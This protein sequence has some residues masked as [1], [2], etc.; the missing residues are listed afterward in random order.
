[1]LWSAA[2]SLCDKE[3]YADAEQWLLLVTNLIENDQIDRINASI[4]FR[5]I[6]FCQI[7]LRRFTEAK[8][9]LER[10]LAQVA[11]NARTL[12][13][14]CI[15]E[16]ELGDAGEFTKHFTSLLQ[17]RSDENNS[18]QSIAMVMNALENQPHDTDIS[19]I[20]LNA[21]E[22]LLKLDS[23]RLKQLE[24]P[25]ATLIRCITRSLR[26][27]MPARRPWSLDLSKY[28]SEAINLSGEMDQAEIDWLA[29]MSWNLSLDMIQ[30][31]E[32]RLAAS[33][34]EL[35][36]QVFMFIIKLHM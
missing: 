36:S 13:L 34:I 24:I 11:Q 14:L 25:H 26:D 27:L 17:D 29:R 22:S 5:K 10:S 31:Q 20:M 9:Y 28:L 15:C 4:V 2:Q 33:Y 12:A 16:S 32:M 23:D 7:Q 6:A 19:E 21:Y 8:T 3:R 30:N 1:L 18:T 35:A